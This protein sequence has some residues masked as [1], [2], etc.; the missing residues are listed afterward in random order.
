MGLRSISKEALVADA[1][2]QLKQDLLAMTQQARAT[3]EG[4]THEES[5]P[6]NSK[7]TRGLEASYLARGQA[8]RVN[9]L[10][11]ELQRL[12]HMP[13]EVFGDDDVIS[14]S[15]LVELCT[16]EG[17]RVTLFL[18]TGGGGISVGVGDVVV[19]LVSPQAPLGRAVLGRELSDEVTL[20]VG[21][22]SLHYESREIG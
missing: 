5:R 1:L 16:L 10:E 17:E 19:Q 6:E 15:A 21:A 18:V 14:A 13:L 22:R 2:A 11:T 8:A 12:Q 3:A 4:A 20:R 9:Q 7:D